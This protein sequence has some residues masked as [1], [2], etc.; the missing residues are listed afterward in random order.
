MYLNNEYIIYKW[1]LSMPRA[2]DT[3]TNMAGIILKKNIFENCAIDMA[4]AILNFFKLILLRQTA[5]QIYD[6]KDSKSSKTLRTATFTHI[7]CS[8]KY[9]KYGRCYP[10]V[11]TYNNTLLKSVHILTYWPFRCILKNNLFH[12]IWPLYV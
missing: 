3:I 1:L 9:I 8:N 10:K 2:P 12:I 4:A 5:T 7:G 11:Q 6:P